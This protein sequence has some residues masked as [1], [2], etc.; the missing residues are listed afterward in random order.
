MLDDS[1]RTLVFADEVTAMPKTMTLAA[2][3]RDVL[4]KKLVVVTAETPVLANTDH[5]P[6]AL[7]TTLDDITPERKAEVTRR[8]RYVMYIRKL[9]LTRGRRSAITQ[10]LNRLRGQVPQ[11]GQGEAAAD[12]R[13][14]GVSTV[15]DWLKRWE[16]GGGHIASLLS[17][18]ATRRSS[19]R[20]VGQVRDVVRTLIRKHYL[21]QTRPTLLETKRHIDTKLEDM[22]RA[23]EIEA[24]EAKISLSTVRRLVQEVNPFERDM[25]RFGA[26]YAKNKWRHSLGGVIAVRP[27]QR[28]EIDHTILDIVVVSDV[29]GMPLGRPTITIVVDAHSSYVAGFFVSFWGTGLAT[30]LAALKVAISPKDD[31]TDGMGLKNPWLAYGI[32]MLLAVDNGLEFHSPQFHAAAMHLSMDL[33]FCPVRMPW[34]K[35]YVERMLQSISAYLPHHGKVEKPRNNYL[36]LRPEKTAAVTFGALCQGLLKIVVDVLPFQPNQRTLA[37]PF[38]RFGEGMEQL[39]PP[40]LPTSTQEL[41]I[42]VAHSKEMTVGTEGVLMSYLRYNSR[43]L[44]ALRKATAANF[45]ALVKFNPEDLSHVYVQDPISRGWLHVPSCSPEYT[46]GLSYVQHKA[47]LANRKGDLERR[48]VYEQLE[49]S[50]RELEDMWNSAAVI[51]KRMKQDAL[52][53]MSGLTSNHALRGSPV[54]AA[55]AHSMPIVATSE[56]ELPQFVIP[57][58]ETLRFGDR[59]VY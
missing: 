21:K 34:F 8:Y 25:A 42:I 52:R 23:G 18:N 54:T 6:A 49:Q 56:M 32:P 4:N 43:E 19:P 58:F 17:R 27:L 14:P 31:F 13:P 9:G 12:L 22:R 1:A 11:D 20:I 57:Q 46:T 2:L 26:S 16:L 37:L 55:G 28:Y 7:V 29:T 33:L 48:N 38:D 36:P 50:K 30:S 45:K 10:A 3:Q 41:D 44:V 47:I 15:M 40:S 59:H 53:R 35:P 24:E 5:R 51:G 39:L